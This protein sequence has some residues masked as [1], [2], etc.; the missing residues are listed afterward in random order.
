MIILPVLQ[1]SW[2]KYEN[3]RRDRLMEARCDSINPPRPDFTDETDFE[4]WE[5]FRYTM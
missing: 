1:L 5:T 4:Q 3:G 2:Y